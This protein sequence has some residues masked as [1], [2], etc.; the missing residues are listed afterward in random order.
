[1]AEV[2]LCV[3]R[4]PLVFRPPRPV[5]GTHPQLSGRSAASPAPTSET[6]EI[7]QG[8]AGRERH[9]GTGGGRPDLAAFPRAD[10]GR[11]RHWQASSVATAA[12][13][14]QT[15]AAGSQHVV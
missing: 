6:V 3:V 13:A 15:S 8:N 1:M 2:G 10:R 4:R 7:V 9:A 11:S 14:A 12:R 5:A